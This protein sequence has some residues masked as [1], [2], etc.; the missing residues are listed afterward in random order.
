[1][2]LYRIIT[3]PIRGDVEATINGLQESVSPGE[4]CSIL[5]IGHLTVS[6]V[7]ERNI[8]ALD[9]IVLSRLLAHF[10]HAREQR[11]QAAPALAGMHALPEPVSSCKDATDWLIKALAAGRDRDAGHPACA[12]AHHLV[13][14]EAYGLV[15]F[16]LASGPGAT[17]AA[18]SRRYGLSLAQFNRRCRHVLGH[19]LKLE[20]RIMRAATALLEYSGRRRTLTHIAQDH[21]YASQSHFCTDIKALIGQSPLSV[22][23]AVTPI[24]E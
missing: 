7:P 4:C 3:P 19:P 12:L 8:I 21:G 2:S 9:P 16:L 24:C 18:L 6:G 10:D 20:L 1:M 11:R 14:E 23:R 5:L 13:R 17:V 22:F 15:R